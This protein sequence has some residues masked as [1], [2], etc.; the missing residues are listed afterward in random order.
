MGAHIK[1]I[2][3]ERQDGQIDEVVASGEVIASACPGFAV[4]LST[5]K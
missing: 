4:Y 5:H 1:E 3:P 2:V